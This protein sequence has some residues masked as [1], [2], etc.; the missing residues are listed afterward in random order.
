MLGPNWPVSS[1]QCNWV[2][3]PASASLFYN[4]LLNHCSC[5]HWEQESNAENV[6]R[7][8]CTFPTLAA[9]LLGRVRGTTLRHRKCKLQLFTSCHQFTKGTHRH[10]YS[11][12]RKLGLQFSPQPEAPR[13]HSVSCTGIKTHRVETILPMA[14]KTGPIAALWTSPCTRS[15][16]RYCHGARNCMRK[17]TWTASA[18]RHHSDPD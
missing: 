7:K 4:S 10:T 6:N 9:I 17:C 11:T 3:L 2:C 15:R 12:M 16:Q 18:Q 8:L 14:S 1:L 13:S 5:R